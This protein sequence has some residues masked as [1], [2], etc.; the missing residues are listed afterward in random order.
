MDRGEARVGTKRDHSTSALTAVRSAR[1]R[2]ARA[3]H[4]I[5]A[6]AFLLA[7]AASTVFAQ[8][9]LRMP[10]L[11]AVDAAALGPVARAQ[12]NALIAEKEARSPA[13]H[14]IDSRL[15][16]TI[17]A[18]RPTPRRSVL[19]TLAKAPVE[20]DGRVVVDIDLADAAAVNHV[21]GVLRQVNG[22]VLFASERFKSIRARV[23][24]HTVE[25][26]ASIAGV[27]FVDSERQAAHNKN[28][29]TQGDV[30][31]KANFVRSSM[32]YTGNGIKVCVMSDG[33]DSLAS[34]QATGDLPQLIDVLPGQAGAGDEGTAMLEILFD[35][36]P[37]ARLGF[38]TTQGGEARFAQNILD[39]ADPAKGGCK[40][41]VDDT[42]YFSESPFQDG[43]AAQAVNSVV[44]AGV[45]FV[46]A[47]A[48]TGNLDYGTSGTWEGDFRAPS[49]MTSALIPGHVLH[50]F[51]PGV[52]GNAALTASS[53]ATLHWAEPYGAAASDY[54][55]YVL[56]ASMSTVLASSTNT[57]NGTQ[58]PCEIVAAPGGGT[59]PAGSRIV[60]AKKTGAQ[61]RMLSLQWYRG[62]LTYATN[63]A[64]RGH[65]AAAGA[66]SVAA[67]P[68]ANADGPTPPNPVGPYPGTY[69]AT[70]KVEI[71]S[72]DGPRR[73]FF[74]GSGNL[75][76]GAVAGNFTSSGGVVRNKPD[77][78]AAD[79][80]AT[81]TPG[82]TQFFGTSAAAPHAA[83]AAAMLKQAFPGWSPQQVKTALLG[84]A[85]DI[86][87]PGWDRTSGA[88]I[89]MPL[90][91]LQANGASAAAAVKLVN[92]V[93]TEV[94]GN[95]NGVPD[96]GEDW[97]FTIP[98]GNSGG[99][100]AT[101]VTATL[102]TSTPGIS[103]TSGPVGYGSVAVNGSVTNPS[104]TP[105]RFTLPNLPC[106]QQLDFVL[107]VTTAQNPSPLYLPIS[108][109]SNPGLGAAQTF[110]FTGPSIAI[111]D[112]GNQTAG[113][114]ASAGL[115]VSG[116]N[117]NIG[118]VVLRID[119]LNG[120]TVNDAASAGID[121]EYVGDLVV[122]LK[123]PDGTLVR[124]V[125]RMNS[126]FNDGQNFCNL[127]LD[128]S[129]VN[130]IGDAA[131]SMAPFT[132]SFRPDASLSGLNGRNPN[133]LWELQANDFVQSKTGHINRFSLIVTPQTCGSVSP[134]P[135]P[136]ANV[137]LSL[138]IDGDG[139]YDALTDGLLVLR[140][141]LGLSGT[142]M[143]DRVVGSGAQRTTA[144]QISAYLDTMRSALDVDG[145][146][147]ADALSDG[148]IIM[149]FMFGMRGATMTD[150]AISA[151][152][153]RT[154]SQIE[155]YLRAL[156][157]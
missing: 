22:Q 63:G 129:A 51:A 62:R 117:G 124:V 58:S 92:V 152:A 57:Q 48:N 35:L 118:K 154:P 97:Q 107:Q 150:G 73:M 7:L 23:A 119:G 105:F 49:G 44:A 41:I 34:R 32:G 141:L 1:A 13:Q 126:G 10:N 64:T 66:I 74:D 36:V 149:R 18:A 84:S 20:A 151:A 80:V 132:G 40:V 98:L 9:A 24:P 46:S 69:S 95:G 85:I 77:V 143:I 114:T 148:L 122:T 8:G 54:D 113:P 86:Q 157:P 30:V 31:H 135:S 67:T 133:G 14:K 72:A 142:S 103:V 137:S 4:P 52:A 56:D 91:A 28:S 33:I 123:A 89:M 108:M 2:H 3:A 21:I 93:A 61:D 145:N 50:E 147:Q 100:N 75:L 65:S 25:T 47:A 16:L 38:A 88:G 17:D 83:A 19:K 94:R 29:T 130:A 104:S 96:S 5:A 112:G 60:V 140:Y 136:P 111:P 121:H 125:N 39:L 131:G 43:M 53:Y 70:G 116:I 115:A 139:R 15:L 12:I 120:C 138:D 82:Y 127:T 45:V 153:T 11:A 109:A 68:A 79:G 76:A 59:F 128:D 27:R 102:T 6:V 55:L 110:S 156:T 81:D 37:E 144:A 101:N 134:P 99:A 87:A 155:S 42:L 90:A 26:I 78:T 146:G 106:G 71:F